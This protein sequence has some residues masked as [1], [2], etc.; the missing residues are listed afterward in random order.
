MPIV[1]TLFLE[2]VNL[3]NYL[4]LYVFIFMLI[5][6]HKWQEWDVAEVYCYVK[7]YFQYP[8]KTCGIL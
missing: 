1:N 5:Y 3:A 2:E 7:Q 6:N 8:R 4:I